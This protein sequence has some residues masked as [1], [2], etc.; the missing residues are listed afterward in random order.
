HLEPK[1]KDYLIAAHCSVEQGH[2]IVL[3]YMGLKPLL[4]LDLRL[5]EGTGSALA[6]SLVEAGIKIMTQMATFQ[7]AGVSEKVESRK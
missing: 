5:G 6:I 1:I 4:D 3:D 2:K 7:D